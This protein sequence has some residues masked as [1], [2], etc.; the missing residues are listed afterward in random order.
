MASE[1][2][3]GGQVS[4]RSSS[5]SRAFVGG[6]FAVCALCSLA[7]SGGSSSARGTDTGSIGDAAAA[8]A[9]L[10]EIYV[11]I[12]QPTC[13]VCHKPRGIGDFQD[14][15]SQ[16]SAYKALVGV[17]ASGPSCGSSGET[18]VVAGNASQSLLFQKVSEANP[19]CGS[20]MPFGGPPLSSAQMTLIEEWIN[21]GALND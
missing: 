20:Q 5:K 16:S 11:T 15:S 17:K 21:A 12:L 14:L 6:F 1:T 9:T 10:T 4:L 2:G 13:S 7:C 8:P 18:R 3:E 19:P